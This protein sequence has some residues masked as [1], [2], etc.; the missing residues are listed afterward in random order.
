MP[1]IA[2]FKSV[3]PARSDAE[4]EKMTS[5]MGYL[6]R[7]TQF[8][9]ASAL[10]KK[11][12][13]AGG[14]YLVSSKDDRLALGEEVDFVPVAWR[15]KALETP[16]GAKPISSTDPN[17]EVFKSIAARSHQPNSNCQ[18]GIE[19]LIWVPSV[20]KFA[21]FLMGS[22]TALKEAA[23]IKPFIGQMVTVK[24]HT[25]ESPQY[26]WQGPKVYE[27]DLEPC[28]LPDE[29]LLTDTVERF[30]TPEEDESVVAPVES[31]NKSKRAR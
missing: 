26:V 19:Y 7:L 31:P 10:V 2:L 17:S 3:V 22:K 1:E 16:P 11:R 27:C 13:I 4:F 21:T 18:T 20:A 8:T 15:F 12:E 29:S 5:A 28:S 25:Y 14:F 30:N 9:D 24:V 6:P 23:K